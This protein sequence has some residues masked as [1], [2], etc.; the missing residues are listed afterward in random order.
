M[1]KLTQ[2]F[3]WLVLFG[4]LA[5]IL[6]P[7]P[8][9]LF[10]IVMVFVGLCEIVMIE[11]MSE[12]LITVGKLEPLHTSSANLVNGA[13]GFGFGIAMAILAPVIGMLFHD[14]EIVHLVWALAP[15]PVLSALSATPVALLRRSL[16]YRRLAV[17][18]I[19]GLMIGGIFGI[20]LAIAGAGVWA[21]ALQVL[22][23]RFGEVTI[24]WMSVPVRLGFRWSAT[25]FREMKAVGMNVFAAQM[26]NLASG[27][28]PRMILG[29]T[30]GPTQLGLF[31]MATRIADIIVVTTAMPYSAVGRI[32]LRASK[33]GSQEFGRMFSA[34][35]QNASI[36]AFPLFL[37]TAA[38]VPDLFRLWLGERWLAGIIPTQLILLG[39]LPFVFFYCIDAALLAANMSL[40]FKRLAAVQ[41][42][43]MIATVLCAAPFGLELTCL[44]LAIRSWLL[45]P[46]F[47]LLMRRSC[48]L[49][50]YDFLRLPIR[51]LMGA[52]VM[53]SILIL[54]LLRPLWLRREYDFVL[55][56]V[57][58][59]LCYGSFLYC[60]SRQQLKSLLAGFFVRRT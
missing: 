57:I 49:S 42:L 15:L 23:Q 32:E 40:V 1:S 24:A 47:L 33:P 37:G 36:L 29:Y 50:V 52:V 48:H 53:A 6:G 35:T 34:M 14:D 4:V 7:R 21:L 20:V 45:L 10:S 44:A 8:Y 25:H 28:L 26:L 31:T 18:S 38:L 3:L 5:P 22:T 43:T 46:F 51:S 11:A 27:Q 56:V 58:G 60:F 13:I 41:T 16:Q 19:A 17:R 9:G 55:L 39:G 12:A 59:M 30:L 2:Q 54:P